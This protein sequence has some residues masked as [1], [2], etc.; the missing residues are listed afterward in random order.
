M[1]FFCWSRDQGNSGD[2]SL[3]DRT[4][5]NESPQPHLLPFPAPLQRPYLGHSVAIWVGFNPNPTPKV[6]ES[7]T[8]HDRDWNSVGDH[9]GETQE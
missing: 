1:I 6:H 5:G 9:L 4:P 8:Y 2:P 7:L 3:G